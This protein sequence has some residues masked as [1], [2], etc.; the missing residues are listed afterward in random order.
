MVGPS[1]AHGKTHVAALPAVLLTTRDAAVNC[2][3]RRAASRVTALLRS[4]SIQ[5]EYPES[6]QQEGVL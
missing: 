3:E 4:S 5:P 6:R 1:L 2:A